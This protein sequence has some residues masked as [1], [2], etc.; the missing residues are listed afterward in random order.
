MY[1]NLEEKELVEKS[2]IFTAKEIYMQPKV[3]EES[4]EI[5]KNKKDEIK[6]FFNI[7]LTEEVRVILTGA[8][9]SDYV[10]DTVE[11]YL[12]RLVKREIEAIATTDIVSAPEDYLEKRKTILVSYARSGNSPE[13]IG[14]FE[15]LDKNIKEIY[16]LVITCNK[17]GD[18][19]KKAENKENALV[20]IMP[21]KSNDKSFAMTSSF[22]A[23]LLS[24]ILAFDIDNLENNKKYLDIIKIQGERIVREDYKQL[25]EVSNYDFDRLVY[26][27]TG[28]LKELS[29][30]MALKNLELTSGKIETVSESVLGFR[31]GPKSIINDKTLIIVMTAVDDYS[32]KYDLDLIREI[33]GDSGNHR[34]VV[35]SYDY[36]R[37]L[38][39]YSDKY[40]SVKGEEVS[41]IFTIFNY[42]LFG[43]IFG[44]LN[45]LKLGI[46]P[47]NPRPDGTVNRVVQGVNIY[48][49]K[50]K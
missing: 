3:W 47:D 6:K 34:L 22:S 39:N 1:F 31:H 10:G 8:G 17:E 36:K 29:Q 25:L 13:S 26:L 42:M 38:E 5:I 46:S 44:M 41:Y 14:A 48:D 32:Y 33:K 23:M 40:I 50:S 27:G 45:S 18:L 37:E 21:E 9:T 30:E 19:A 11:K 4:Y 24:T 43:Q 28:F 7:A 20:L 15:I 35:I 2:A 16:H 12:R 49:Y